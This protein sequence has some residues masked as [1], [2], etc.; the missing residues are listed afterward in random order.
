VFESR[1]ARDENLVRTETGRR[2]VGVKHWP[3]LTFRY[4][5]G[6]DNVLGSTFE[7]H[8]FNLVLAH[9]VGAGQLGRLSYR[10]EGNYIPSALPYPVLKTPLGNETPF[11][12]VNAFNLM[13]YFEF[14]TDRSV[15]LR[16]EQH[17]EGLL[18]NAVPGIRDLDWRLVASANLLYGGLSTT[19]ANLL[20]PTDRNGIPLTRFQSLGAVPYTEISYGVE[21]IFKFVRVDFLHRVTYRDLP[22]ARNFGVKLTA[23]FRL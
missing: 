4:T 3:V 5:L 1:Y 2:A 6:L 16:L 9:S 17:F 22:G 21:N 12:N 15:A 18:L 7:Y 20:P 23:Q 13:R 11:L 19:N 14:V 10:L 8:K